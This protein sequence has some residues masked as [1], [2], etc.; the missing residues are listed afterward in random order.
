MTTKT[1]RYPVF[2]FYKGIT[3]INAGKKK[4]GKPNAILCVESLT[5]MSEACAKALVKAYPALALR[6][7]KITK[8]DTRE[9]WPKP[10]APR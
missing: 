7:M 2:E 6:C 4:N 3:V 1:K 5:V 8:G 9:P 10:R